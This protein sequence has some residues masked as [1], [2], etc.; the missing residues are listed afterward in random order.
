MENS[1]SHAPPELWPSGDTPS[2]AFCAEDQRLR[3][4][5]SFGMDELEA[6]QELT[7]IAS[8]A[9]QLC[10]VPIAL[11]SLVEAERQRFLAREGTQ[12][13]ET[14]RSTSFCAHA[15]L[16]QGMMVIP[17][18]LE[19]DT[20][21]DFD[22]VHNPPNVRFY[23]GVPLI[24]AEGAP[25][26]A[27]C[28]IDPKPR[29]DGLSAF[30]I[31]GLQVL[32]Q[33]VMRRLYAHRQ[34]LEANA[35]LAK[36]EAQFRLLADA[37][38][39]IAWSSAA[40]GNFDYFNQRWYEF[41]GVEE[42]P[43]DGWE[44]I[45]HPEDRDA[46]SGAWEQARQSGADYEAEFRLRRADGSWRWMLSRG[47]PFRNEAGEIERWFGTL[48]DI[49]AG[50]RL[51]QDRELLAGELAHRIKNIFA[52]ISGLVGLRARGDD[53]LVAFAN[54]LTSTIHALSR[55]QDLV[56]PLDG[57]GSEM[58]I[59]LDALLAPYSGGTQ[60]SVQVSG[61]PA[62]FGAKAATPLALIFHELG[63]NAAKYG[64]LSQETG[65]LSIKVA[66]VDDKVTIVWRETGGPPVAEPTSEGFG[67][68][69]IA[70]SVKNQLGGTIQHN[71]DSAG[72][73]VTIALPLERLQA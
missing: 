49:D 46:W 5:A 38:P 70:R 53:T 31:D 60:A 32:A 39:D 73:I 26:G 34:Q 1:S 66:Q 69:L 13:S 37:I 56:R 36:S 72:L 57:T 12:E 4:M 35:A 16:G 6:D 19:D 25:L 23:A 44:T 29:P 33:A 51:S 21:R 58:P 62:K 30:Q 41:S 2:P 61:D 50:H 47:T 8:F 40:D 3:V 24:S 68:R 55:A 63:T 17:D 27:L 14:P 10:G 48:T 9:A 45:F 20:F 28:I 54:D 18:A 52:V 71:W 11:V 59:L 67:S 65:K 42:R 7:N 22:L 43:A 15:M 64:A